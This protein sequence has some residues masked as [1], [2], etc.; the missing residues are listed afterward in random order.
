MG[1]MRHEDIKTTMRCYV[2]RDTKTRSQEL[3]DATP[4][5]GDTDLA[6]YKN[7][8]DKDWGPGTR[9]QNK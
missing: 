3:R 4:G 9:T 8:L 7:R 6:Q 2:E 1:L 5:Q